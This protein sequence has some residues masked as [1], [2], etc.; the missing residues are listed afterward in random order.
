MWTL[1]NS[2]AKPLNG[3]TPGS[4]GFSSGELLDHGDASVSPT[5]PLR[6][7]GIWPMKIEDQSPPKEHN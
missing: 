5:E 1:S 4:R 2:Y 3:L 6:H 7:C